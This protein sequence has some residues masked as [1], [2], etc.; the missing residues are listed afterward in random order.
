MACGFD[1]ADERNEGDQDPLG[2]RRISR[3]V[4]PFH[5]HELVSGMEPHSTIPV[6]L[7]LAFNP[8][9]PILPSQLKPIYG[10]ATSLVKRFDHDLKLY[11]SVFECQLYD[12]FG[13]RWEFDLF[14]NN[15]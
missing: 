12:I 14:R 7:P 15:R 6:A 3:I 11:F 5:K 4:T 13:I 9:S 10:L 1:R 2:Q 8:F